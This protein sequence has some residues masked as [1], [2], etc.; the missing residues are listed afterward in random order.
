[1]W[2]LLT[3]ITF[4]FALAVYLVARPPAVSSFLCPQCEKELN[5]TKAFCPYCGH[6]LSSSFC[7][8]C[9]YQVKGD[10]QFCPNCRYDL[11]RKPDK[12]SAGKDLQLKQEAQQNQP[13]EPK[14]TKTERKEKEKEIEKET[15]KEK[16]KK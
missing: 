13:G 11:T 7:P 8:Q 1:L 4:G 10:W 9:Q 3:V 15:A 6:D 16:D 2:A 14:E 5:G 12:K